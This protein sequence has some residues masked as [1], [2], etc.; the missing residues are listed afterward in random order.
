MKKRGFRTFLQPDGI[1]RLSTAC[2]LA[3]GVIGLTG[4]DRGVRYVATEKDAEMAETQSHL[5]TLDSQQSTLIN[6]EVRNNFHIPSVG[7]YHAESRNF[8]E[9]PYGFEKDSRWYANGIWQDAPV[10]ESVASSRPT[11]EALKKVEEALEKEQQQAKNPPPTSG[12]H[13]G[14]GMGNA[15]MMYWLL[16]GN[17]G[18]FTPGAGF[19]QASGQASSWQQQV[20]SQRSAVASHA[21]ANPGYQRM[22]AQS[23]TNGTPVK[24]GQSVRGGFGSHSSGS[25]IGS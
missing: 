22:V 4:C 6:G 2:I 17:R 1:L 25:S 5:E 23:R 19:R 7:Y 3:G 10:A 21:A 11:P 9:H 14:F 12:G 8:F 13:H 20:D 24:T 15:L 16:A 18:S